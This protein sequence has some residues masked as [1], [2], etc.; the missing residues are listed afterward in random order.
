MRLSP[1]STDLNRSKRQG[2]SV[3][4]TGSVLNQITGEL[5]NSPR[6][7]SSPLRKESKQMIIVTQIQYDS[8]LANTISVVM[9]MMEADDSKTQKD[10]DKAIE[11]ATKQHQATYQVK[12]G[13]HQ[14]CLTGKAKEI[15]ES[16]VLPAHRE[17]NNLTINDGFSGKGG[18]LLELRPNFKKMGFVETTT[19]TTDEPVETEE[20]EGTDK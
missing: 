15:F 19:E 16:K 17:L 1:K 6:F 8:I 14:D 18:C 7:V 10:I 4:L 12:G 5:T 2:T 20:S 3:N 13:K 9:A 11:E